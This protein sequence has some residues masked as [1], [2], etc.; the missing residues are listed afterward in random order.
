LTVLRRLVA[1]ENTVVLV[2]HDMPVIASADWM[3]DLG[4]GGGDNGG[5]IIASGPPTVVAETAGSATAAYL[6]RHLAV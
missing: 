6:A 5:R 3:I 2:E 1:A 4:P